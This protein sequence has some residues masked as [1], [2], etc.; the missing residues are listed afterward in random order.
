MTATALAERNMMPARRLLAPILAAAA[1]LAAPLAIAP[2]AE[3]AVVKP[4]DIVK[5]HFDPPGAD[6]MNNAGY[7]KEFIQLKNT[8]TTTLNLTGYRILDSG[9]QKFTFPKNFKLAKGK[10]VTIRSGKGSNSATALYWGTSSYIWNNTGDTARLLNP[11][12]KVLEI[13]KH[14]RGSTKAC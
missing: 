6:K 4:L 11:K 2:A 12:G 9:P 8:G 1:L 7:N 13:C 5:I 10:T 3:A 14:G